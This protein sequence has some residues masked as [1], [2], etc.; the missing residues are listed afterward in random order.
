M[1]LPTTART[2]MAV[3]SRMGVICRALIRALVLGPAL[4]AAAAGC[5]GS[6]NAGVG[7]PASGTGGSTPINT[8]GT[9]STDVAITSNESLA[10][11]AVAATPSVVY[12]RG[13]P[14]ANSKVWVAQPNSTP[15][16]LLPGETRPEAWPRLS[17]DGT[18]VYFMRDMK[19]LSRANLDGTGVVDLVTGSAGLTGI[20]LAE[21]P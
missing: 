14:S 6:K 18:W 5:G 2:P 16:P 7:A 10:P 13:D 11:S 17:P 19:T 12:Y 21:L 20:A 8:D 4:Y 15:Q 3:T 9:G 1:S